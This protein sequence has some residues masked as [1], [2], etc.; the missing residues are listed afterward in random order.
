MHGT[1][2]HFQTASSRGAIPGLV[3]A[4]AADGTGVARELPAGVPIAS[5]VNGWYWLHFNLAENAAIDLLDSLPELP[6]PA[7]RLFRARDEIPQLHSEGPVTYGLIV[8]LQRDIGATRE[9]LGTLHF[10]MTENILIT[11]RRSSLNAAG[12]TRQRL[13][14]GLRVASV[15]NLLAVIVEQVVDG[16]DVH[17]ERIAREVDGLEDRIISGSVGD[18][19]ARL[20]GYRRTTVRL[21]RHITELRLLFQRIDRDGKRT[22]VP[23]RI[24]RLASELLQ[25]S[26]V[27]DRDIAALGDRA[28]LLQEE[29]VTLLTEETNRHLRVLSVLSILFLP[30]TFIA[31]IFGMNLK[32]MLFEGH[33]MGFWS[34]T[35]LALLS[36]AIVLAAMRRIGVLAR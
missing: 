13:L 27:L 36:S 3:W 17:I 1:L 5:D 12:A 8:D 20:A 35:A 16:V 9:D 31:G 21:R 2:S 30:P 19:R 28:R 23:A 26:E 15:E 11:G 33:E 7:A 34:A 10:V 4:L 22:A 24:A 14:D 25:E 32:G 6:R 29:V 18:A